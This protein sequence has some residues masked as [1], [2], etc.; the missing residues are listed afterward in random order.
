M[1]DESHHNEEEVA[2]LGLKISAMNI[3]QNYLMPH[4][5]TLRYV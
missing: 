1:T 5:R 3:S 2:Y 4:R